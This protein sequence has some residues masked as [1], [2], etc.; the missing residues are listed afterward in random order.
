[1]SAERRWRGDVLVVGGGLGGVAAALAVARLG[2]TAVL[3]EGVSADGEV[4]VEPWPLSAEGRAGLRARV[5][6]ARRCVALWL[7]DGREVP[8]TERDHDGVCVLASAAW[9]HAPRAHAPDRFHRL[10]VTWARTRV[11]GTAAGGPTLTAESA[12]P[13]DR[14]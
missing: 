10:S 14:A 5:A 8:L 11:M 4:A 7:M 3:T 1:M 13:R 12:I 6:H 9:A 2:R